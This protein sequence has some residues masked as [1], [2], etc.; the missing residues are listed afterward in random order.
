M[1]SI[2]GLSS[3]VIDNLQVILGTERIDAGLCS[4]V[5][6]A[7]FNMTV[8]TTDI[9]SVEDLGAGFSAS[10]CGLSLDPTV[11]GGIRTYQPLLSGLVDMSGSINTLTRRAKV[12][13]SEVQGALG[14]NYTKIDAYVN[15]VPAVFNTF[16]GDVTS[17][18]SVDM[19]DEWI[20]TIE[21]VVSP[22]LE[23]SLMSA[24]GRMSRSE[25]LAINSGFVQNDLRRRAKSLYNSIGNFFETGEPGSV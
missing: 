17:R 18:L 9:L 5:W 1:G 14:V 2:N 25:L 6:N 23:E 16:V 22:K 11:G 10:A 15:D 8:L 12:D 21:P 24:D 19:K 3:F 13:W 4:T 20:E 7:V